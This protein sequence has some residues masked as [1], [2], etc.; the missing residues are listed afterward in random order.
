M[1]ELYQFEISSYAEKI[2]FVLD[3]K[4]LNY[5]KVEVLPAIGQVEVFKLSGQRQVPVLKD[6]GT[7]I[8]D[9]T[10]IAEFLDRKY[11]DKPVIPTDL[12]T[13]GQVMLMEQWADEIFGINA[14]KGLILSMSQNPSFRS[15]LLPSTTPD[16]LKN[17]VNSIPS[18]DFL[19]NLGA[20]VGMSPDKIKDEIRQNLSWLCGILSDQ[21]YLTGS[22]PTLADFTVAALS[23][24]IKF[25]SGNYIDLPESVKG[26]GVLGIADNPLYDTFWTWRDKLYSDFRKISV[27]STLNSGNASASGPTSIS[28]D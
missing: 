7:V 24:Y 12:K 17:L 16:V 14:R 6:E 8:A 26:K 1:I 13:R 5:K 19:G 10:S 2:R 27:P 3:Y 11:S 4:G 21:P 23:M 22:E 9:S 18:L 15:A 20:S 25:P 28:I